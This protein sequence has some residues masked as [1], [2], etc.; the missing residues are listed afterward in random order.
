MARSISKWTCTCVRNSG[1]INRSRPTAA[2]HSRMPILAPN[3]VD[4]F[5]L[6]SSGYVDARHE[7]NIS[8]RVVPSLCETRSWFDILGRVVVVAT[9]AGHAR[10]PWQHNIHQ[11]SY[12]RPSGPAG[13]RKDRRRVAGVQRNPAIWQTQIKVQCLKSNVNLETNLNGNSTG[14]N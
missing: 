9:N 11:S 1:S 10:S 13:H 7:T 12:D 6:E 4:S 5:A 14:L 8:V 2:L 3:F